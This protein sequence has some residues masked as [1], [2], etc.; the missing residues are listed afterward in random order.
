[1]IYPAKVT[2]RIA[3]LR[4][5]GRE[6]FGNSAGGDANF[7]CGSFVRFSL[8]IDTDSKRVIDANFVSNGCGFML[9][10]ADVLARNIIGRR[11]VDLNTLDESGLAGYT[12]RELGEI[13][14]RRDEC[15]KACIRA[16]CSAF[17]DHRAK[18]IE[19]FRGEK[20]LICTC[21]GVTAETIELQIAQRGLETVDDVTQICNAGGGCGSCRMLIQE[22]LDSKIGNEHYVR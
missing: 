3:Q 6:D 19:E 11:L 5:I 12:S 22:M 16:L 1:M 20:E 13:P 10:A 7:R 8:S 4:S 17:S 9:A 14:G 2:K 21:F 18:Q 15:V